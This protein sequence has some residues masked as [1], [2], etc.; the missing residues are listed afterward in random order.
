MRGWFSSNFKLCLSCIQILIDV[1]RNM[2]ELAAF[3]ERI[4]DL[5]R[6]RALQ[7]HLSWDQQTKMPPKEPQQGEK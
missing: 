3:N 7:S 2:S 4:S 6:L 1:A 5:F